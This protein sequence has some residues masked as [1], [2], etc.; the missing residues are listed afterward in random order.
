MY[1]PPE[2][3]GMRPGLRI[4]IF[5]MLHGINQER[6]SLKSGINRASISSWEKGTYEPSAKAVEALTPHLP[7]HPGYIMFGTPEIT[8]GVWQPENPLAKRYISYYRKDLKSLFPLFCKENKITSYALYNGRDGKLIFLKRK[9]RPFSYLIIL[10]KK[11]E[12]LIEEIL[13][14]IPGQIITLNDDSLPAQIPGIQDMSPEFLSKYFTSVDIDIDLEQITLTLSEVKRFKGLVN[15]EDRKSYGFSAYMHFTQI[16]G[17]YEKPD[18]S[19]E[20]FLAS[21]F[22]QTLT[23]IEERDLVWDGKIDPHIYSKLRDKLER[24]GF[25]C[26]N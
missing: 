2:R 8:S 18:K 21:C 23:E 22:S 5:R 12:E 15:G 17:E 14:D 11:D 16:I 3:A 26:K 9:N 25:R 24:K 19:C 10:Q 6:L 7:C 4:K 13:C 20:G 1:R